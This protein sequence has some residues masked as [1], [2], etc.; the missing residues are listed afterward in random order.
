M[1]CSAPVCMSVCTALNYKLNLMSVA[2]SIIA[3]RLPE[4]LKSQHP[5]KPTTWSTFPFFFRTYAGSLLGIDQGGGGG[6]IQ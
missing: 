3:Q 2:T 4:I 6:G 5:R 1:M